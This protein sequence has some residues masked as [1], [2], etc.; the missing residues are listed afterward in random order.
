MAAILEGFTIIWVY[1]KFAPIHVHT[2]VTEST[3]T[4][5]AH[6]TTETNTNLNTNC[7]PNLCYRQSLVLS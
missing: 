7:N 2:D 4:K 6:C 1:G 5:N 3:E